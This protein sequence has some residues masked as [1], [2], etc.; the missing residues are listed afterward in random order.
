VV[1]PRRLG[2]RPLDGL[3]VRRARAIAPAT[4]FSTFQHVPAH[5]L[6]HTSAHLSTQLNTQNSTQISTTQHDR[7][8]QRAA[9]DPLP[10]RFRC[11]SDPFGHLQISASLQLRFRTLQHAPARINTLQHA[12]AR[13]NTTQHPLPAAPSRSAPYCSALARCDGAQITISN[14]KLVSWQLDAR[15]RTPPWCLSTLYT[16]RR[17]PHMIYI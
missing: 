9:S 17:A 15:P 10:I 1:V 13:S 16:P 7:Q 2:G 14:F 12:P 11:A 6:Q 3:R 4:R 5:T 8:H